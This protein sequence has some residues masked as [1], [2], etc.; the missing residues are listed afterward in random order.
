MKKTTHIR[1]FSAIFLALTLLGCSKK[2]PTVE[3]ITFTMAEVNPEDSICGKMDIAFKQK[4]EE[5]SNGQMIVDLK[6]S[7]V[8]GDEVQIMNL[9]LSP[10]S[11]VQIARV[12]ASLSSYGGK[13][14]RLITIPYTFSGSN[15]FWKFAASDIAQTILDEPYEMGLGVKGLC[16][17]EEGFRHFFSTSKI[18]TIDDI[19]GKNMRVSGQVL[20][21][22]ANSLGANPMKIAFTDVYMSLQTGAVDIADQPL[23][24]YKSNSFDEVAPYIILDKHMLGAVQILMTSQAWDGLSK[25]QQDMVKEA[26]NYASEYCHKICEEQEESVLKELE[27]KG[28]TITNVEDLTPWQTACKKMIQDSSKEYSDL[29]QSILNLNY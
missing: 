19:V 1:T 11:P 28:V 6:C 9:M 20:T 7:G 14:S 25:A 24:N 13:K 8:L 26:S 22:L 5:L 23:S 2:N 17:A 29:Y 12:S 3:K 27:K 10:D 21:D 18:S 15:H 16:Y 4:L